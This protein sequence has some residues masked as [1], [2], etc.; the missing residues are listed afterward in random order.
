MF[1]ADLIHCYFDRILLTCTTNTNIQRAK[2]F[3]ASLAKIQP[4]ETIKS[5]ASTFI[6]LQEAGPPNCRG[7]DPH[8]EAE[9]WW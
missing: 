5:N 6:F 8:R 9:S 1:L 3:H 7:I 2:R 4:A